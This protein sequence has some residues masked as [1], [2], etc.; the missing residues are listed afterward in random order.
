MEW[1]LTLILWHKYQDRMHT[2]FIVSYEWPGIL[3]YISFIFSPTK[4][5]LR[6]KKAKIPYKFK[7]SHCFNS[8]FTGPC[9]RTSI[10]Q[11]LLHAFYAYALL[12]TSTS[13]RDAKVL[14]FSVNTVY[15]YT[16]MLAKYNRRNKLIIFLCFTLHSVETRY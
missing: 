8:K 16:C 2:N 15:S 11:Y 7:N 1:L 4:N 13:R 9:L 12:I 5:K 14:V 10:L 3:F 6:T